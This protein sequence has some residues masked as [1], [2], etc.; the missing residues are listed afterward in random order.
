MLGH[1]YVIAE[2]V[3]LASLIGHLQA[4]VAMKWQD[5]SPHKIRFV[6]VGENVR[7]EVLDWGG[8]GKPIVLLAGGGDTAHVFDDFATKLKKHNHVY[9]I[10]R[11]GFGA[12]G[13][14]DAT[15]VGDR[16]GNDVLAVIDALKLDKP[17]LAGHSIAG[18]EM[19]WMAKKHPDRIVGLVYLEAGYSYAFDNGEGSSAEEM[20]S[21]KAPQ[22]PAP[23][24]ADLLSFSALQKYGDR[25]NGFRVPEAELRAE[26]LTKSDGTVGD[27]RNSPGGPMLMK[28]IAG[29]Q[30]YTKI[31]VPSLFIFANPHSLGIWVDSSGDASVRSS[32]KVYSDALASLT[33]KQEKAVQQGLPTARVITLHGAN[34]YVFLSTETDVLRYVSAFLRQLN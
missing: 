3:V 17:V 9:G 25:V 23:T 22:P 16:L 33:E 20:M 31:R 30:K 10:T 4:Q 34:H 1:R 21:L 15:D 18:A 2:I 26:R 12:S 8:S 5:P 19:S 6:S 14:A 7:L 27:W 29:R 11:R 32:A 24:A 13:Y 28:L